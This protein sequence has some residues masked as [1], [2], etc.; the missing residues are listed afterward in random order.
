MNVVEN[1]RM[2]LIIARRFGSSDDLIHSEDKSNVALEEVVTKM[3][4]TNPF[5]IFR[6]NV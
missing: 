6:R 5:S 2:G 4:V 3:F 1:P